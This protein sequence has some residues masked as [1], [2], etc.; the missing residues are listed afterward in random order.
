MDSNS[1]ITHALL[2]FLLGSMTIAVN[3]QEMAQ[4]HPS[5][6]LSGDHSQHDSGSTPHVHHAHQA[7]S[8]MVEY[9]Y[10]RMEM[11]DLLDG[12]DD[13]SPGEVTA[14]PSMGGFGFLMS[15]ESMTMDMHMVMAMY[16]I[17]DQVTLMGML[18]YLDLEMDMVAANGDESKMS[19][20]GIGDTLLGAMY[21]L[22]PAWTLSLG[23]SVPTGSIDEEGDMD[24]GAMTMTDVTLP[25]P[26]QL[27]SGTYDLIPSVTYN[28]HH[29]DWTAGG[30]FSYTYRIGENDNDYT[31][32]D[33]A[34]ASAWLKRKLIPNLMVSGQ[35]NYA[36]WGNI[37]GA[38]ED[39]PQTMVMMNNI[40]KT[41]PTADPDLQGGSRM[42][43]LLGVNAMF[44]HG[45]SL[46]LN[47]GV[48]IMQDLDG[49]Q[50]KTDNLLS[51]WYRYSAI[52]M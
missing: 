46:G 48:P 47:Y 31:L 29:N 3:A 30:Q 11:E 43:L 34:E 9:T 8:W 41:S 15:P 22:N 12:T 44:G 2:L 25:Y 32:G 1:K 16:G 45:H 7:G 4:N 26:M 49:P 42:D 36:D 18:N 52:A 51:I 23:L 14:M 20:S 10:M 37:D 17:T 19:T 5:G 38:D 33:R 13:V 28:W 40:M 39:I 35:L 24:M 6:H 21:S 50:M 27:G